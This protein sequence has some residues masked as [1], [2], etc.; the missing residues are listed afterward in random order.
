MRLELI[1]V[2]LLLN[3]ANHCTTEVAWIHKA[4][5]MGTFSVCNSCTSIKITRIFIISYCP[6]EQNFG[7][8][9]RESL[10]IILSHYIWWLDEYPFALYRWSLKYVDCIPWS[11]ER[12]RTMDCRVGFDLH[13][14][15]WL[16][17]CRTV[18]MWSNSS[19]SLHQD[20]F[21]IVA[22][23]LIRISSKCQ[24]DQLFKISSACHGTWL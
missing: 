14:I 21:S 24:I 8:L 16:C 17:F 22:E 11:E 15:M 6:F 7:T 18:K 13:Q 1:R 19:L 23:V 10:C 9:F 12:A 2:S 3:I 4:N 20:P 5:F